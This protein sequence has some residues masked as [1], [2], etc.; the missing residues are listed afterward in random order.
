MRFSLLLALFPLALAAPSKRATP[1]PLHVPRST[2]SN[3][4]EG[5]YIVKMYDNAVADSLRTLH[6]SM[7][8]EPDHIYTA[9]G[10]KGF[11]SAL[12][13]EE[14]ETLQ[15]HPDVEFIE[16]DSI[17]SINAYVTQSGST[18]GLARISHKSRT[19]TGYVYDSSAG[20]GTCSY[21][22]DTG[23]YTAHSEFEG[24][25]T[26]LANFADSSNSDGNGHGTHVAGTVGSKTYGVAKATKLYAVKVLNAGGS[27]TTSGVVAGMNFVTSDVATRSCPAGAVA[28]MSLGGSSSTAINSAA[29][30]MIAA[31]VFL[32]VAAGNSNTDAASTSPAGESQVCTVGATTSSDARAS[33]SNYGSVVDVFAPGQDVLSTWNSGGTNTISGTSMASPHIAG[34]G[35][36]LLALEGFKAPQT[37]CSYIASIGTSGALSGVPSST[38]NKLAFNGNPSG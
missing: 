32:A 20:S 8:A 34:L 38:V 21:I 10:F 16:Q 24:R 31:N 37:L 14:V 25:A 19:A 12:T 2:G 33:F 9:P 7:A 36:Y 23:I 3:L 17:V 11:A 1:A 6:S 18:W 35:A 27:G 13:A 22:V 26:W 4:I 29:R 30:A 28:N 15:N 5:K